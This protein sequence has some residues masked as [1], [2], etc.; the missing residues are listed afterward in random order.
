MKTY[1][2]YAVGVLWYSG[3]QGDFPN[4]SR[5]IDLVTFSR[6]EAQEAYLQLK[7]ED[8]N[9]GYGLRAA[10]L[11]RIEFGCGQTKVHEI[12]GRIRP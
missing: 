5:E 3:D 6:E 12:C 2:I 11:M 4:T 10:Y 8:R 1:S 7:S 9:W